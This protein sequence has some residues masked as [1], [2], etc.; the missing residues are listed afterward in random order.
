MSSDNNKLLMR[1]KISYGF[2]DLAS[3]LYWQ[4]F[5]LY[6]TYFYTDIFVIPAAAAA[7]LFLMSRIFDGVN[8]PVMGM[9]ADRTNTRWGK[10]RPY[11]IWMSIPL[12]VI[13]VLTFTSPDLSA[14]G[15]LV[16]AYITFILFMMAYTAINIPYSALM[17]VI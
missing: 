10:F 4:T 13:A 9:I 11:L 5:M 17:G 15:K 1:E 14:T 12:A 6:F 3:L 2:G 8:D 7:T 16:Y